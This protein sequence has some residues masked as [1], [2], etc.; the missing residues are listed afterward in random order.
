MSVHSWGGYC[1]DVDS[2]LVAD[3]LATERFGLCYCAASFCFGSQLSELS[4]SWRG[5]RA[6]GISSACSDLAQVA[7]KPRGLERT[8]NTSLFCVGMQWFS[9]PYQKHSKGFSQALGESVKGCK[10]TSPAPLLWLSCSGDFLA[11]VIYCPFHSFSQMLSW[12]SMG[13]TKVSHFMDPFGSLSG[14]KPNLNQ[15]EIHTNTHLQQCLFSYNINAL[16]P[17]NTFL[18][19][20]QLSLILVVPSE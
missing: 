11:K 3:F 19:S 8:G 9:N 4:H 2:S 18:F 5:A 10:F 12:W 13:L 20:L 1:L 14:V 17:Q 16:F 15:S 6:I 7:L